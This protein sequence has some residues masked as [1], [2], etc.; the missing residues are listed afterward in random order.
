MRARADAGSLFARALVAHASSVRLQ[1]TVTELR[2]RQWSSATFT[3]AR[4]SVELEC[5]DGTLLGRWT[6]ALAEADLPMRG[7]YL[8]DLVVRSAAGTSMSIDALIL[9]ED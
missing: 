2:M 7:Q 4:V 3:G 9:S 6:E 8:A 1:V 5:A